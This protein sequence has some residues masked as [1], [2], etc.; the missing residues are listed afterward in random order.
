ML[1]KRPFKRENFS[2]SC[3]NSHAAGGLQYAVNALKGQT[4]T[5][6]FNFLNKMIVSTLFL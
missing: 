3:N 1:L 4:G 6:Q 5:M 2:Q